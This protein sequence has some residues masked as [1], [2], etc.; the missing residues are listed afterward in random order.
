LGEGQSTPAPWINVIANPSFGFL[1]SESGS[2]YTWSGNSRENRLTP[3]SNDPVTDAPG[4]AFLVRDDETGEIWGPT[5]LPV[6]DAWP[7]VIRHGQGY[8]R[9]EHESRGIALELLQFVPL[10]ET[11]KVS[12]LTVRNRST[13]TRR[14]TVAA[15]AE[16]VL[17]VSRGATAPFTVTQRDEETGALFATN[18][19]NEEFGGG[20][21]FADL[22]GRQ[23]AWTA[24]RTEFL[25]RNGGL[26]SPS[27]LAPEVALSGRAGAGLDPC[28]ALLRSLEL[29]P[30]AE[31]EV[32]FLLGQG[33]D[34]ADARRLVRQMRAA[35]LDA[36][37]DEVRR[38]WDDTL[39]ALQ[40]KTP[41]RSM[42]LMLNRWLL[43]QVLACRVWA[44]A[45][46]YQSSGAFGFRDQLQDVMALS[47]ARR[48]VVRQHLLRAAG[49]QFREGDV[50]HWWHEPSGRG[51]RTRISDDL[52][53]LPHA[54]VQ[55]IEVTGDRAVLD[56]TVPFLEGAPLLPGE[57]ERYFAPR[58]SEE[59]ATLFE[60]AA[61]ALDRS[62]AVGRHGLPL[63]GTG[64]WNDGMNRVGAGGH[65]ES[66]WLAWFLHT[67]LWEFAGLAEQRG[68]T[69]RAARWRAHVE[70]LGKAV[71]REG[72]DGDWYRRAFFDDGTP[73]GSSAN[74]ECRI[75]SV[76]QSWGVISGAADPQ[77]RRRAMAAVEEYLVRR[78]DGLVLLLTPPFDHMRPDPG[79]IKG[80]L[81]GVRENG[82]QYTHAALWA[83]IAFAALGEG[84]KAGELFDILNPINHASTRSGLHR[85]KVEPYV[86]A[87]D[88][89]AE[90]PHVG[91]GGWTWYTGSAGWMYR[92]GIE[93]ILGFRLRGT[94]LHIDPCIPR[95]WPGY[96]ITFRYH[97]A[98]YRLTVENPHGSTRGVA[99]VE[100]DG[101][102]IEIRE[103]PLSNDGRQHEILVV[104]A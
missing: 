22:G 17:G 28:A 70:A 102:P 91:R 83:V 99:K 74:D 24:D 58:I 48:D 49:R 73:L 8:S 77:R 31:A 95:A 71:E 63:M 37:L 3:W 97:S 50:Q 38:F 65:G 53:W 81:P 27:G 29:Q 52:L 12:R 90:P 1:V 35:N 57:S 46:F 45:A 54:L 101:Q 96:E 9:F 92:A 6:R 93:W 62:L 76:A 42:D 87:A 5:A 16:W 44:R 20:V 34:A 75:D 39:G 100:L 66:V 68:E 47:A 67:T 59:R 98:R 18:A 56:E 13:S 85:Y 69:E 11:V 14:L 51:V 40:V 15:Y 94:R 19:W 4:E 41:D 30:G 32:V 79:Y 23:T 7:Y 89:Y 103:I 36:A 21:A 25:G 2:G 10:A 64:D 43:Y 82:G 88:I 80:Y 61:R 55:F 84:D 26:D 78:G 104:L 33:A 72:W 60:H 86:A